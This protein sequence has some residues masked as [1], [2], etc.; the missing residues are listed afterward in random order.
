MCLIHLHIDMSSQ[1]AQLRRIESKADFENIM[2]TVI[3][4]GSIQDQLLIKWL[5]SRR[6]NNIL[7]FGIKNNNSNVEMD[8]SAHSIL[9]DG[10]KLTYSSDENDN[11]DKLAGRII[12]DVNDVDSKPLTNIII[13]TKPNN[14][15]FNALNKYIL[16]S[17]TAIDHKIAVNSNVDISNIDEYKHLYIINARSKLNDV[18]QKIMHG[19]PTLMP[20]D[21]LFFIYIILY[22][23]NTHAILDDI[24]V[25]TEN[26]NNKQIHNVSIKNMQSAID[27]LSYFVLG[28]FS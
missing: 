24:T 14:A 12:R 3:H 25:V 10:M 16:K 20:I 17:N 5:V 18:T 26:E 13:L 22:I 15:L 28:S 4:T 7:A 1:Y 21:S 23:S 9:F 27:A 11:M 19:M 2:I 8:S 6:L